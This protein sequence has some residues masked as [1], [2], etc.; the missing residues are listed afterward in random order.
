M[1]R[2]NGSIKVFPL[3]YLPQDTFEKGLKS[4]LDE[5]EKLRL[6][7]KEDG[8]GISDNAEK[9]L[10]TFYEET[11]ETAKTVSQKLADATKKD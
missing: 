6:K 10:K 8:A 2:K 5:S 3:Y 7:I 9:I 1:T 11:V 4:V